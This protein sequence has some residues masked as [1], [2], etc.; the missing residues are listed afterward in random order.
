MRSSYHEELGGT[1]AR[2][3]EM[4]SLVEVAIRALELVLPEEAA[5]GANVREVLGLDDRM[6]TI[7]LTPNRA[8]CL[9]LIGVAREVAALTG[10]KLS[11]PDTRPV[12]ATIDA[13]R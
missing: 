10:A 7:K 13:T 11:L 1:L 4:A 5:V 3:N 2:L 12:A 8:D 9:S 6:F